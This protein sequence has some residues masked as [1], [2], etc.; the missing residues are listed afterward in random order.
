MG[1]V[2]K[3]SFVIPAYNE[4]H[5]V[6]DCLDAIL[7]Q[8]DG[9]PCPLEII[10]VNNASTDG[11][12]AVV[13]RYTDRGVTLV[14]EPEKGLVHA[15]RAGYDAATGDIIA[16]VDADT[17]ITPGWIDKVYRAFSG[18]PKLVAL[19]GPFV[20][21]DAPRSVRFWTLVFYGIGYVFYIINRFILR[22]GSMLQGGN[23]VVRR[24]AMDAIGGYDESISFYGE[25]S[26]VARRLSKVGKVRFTFRFPAFSSARRLAKEGSFMMGLR[27]SVN[28]FWM[29]F[30]KRPWTKDYIDIRFKEKSVANF[31]PEHK[32]REVV[33]ALLAFILFVVIVGGGSYVIYSLAE[34]GTVSTISLVQWELRARQAAS[35][36]E[37]RIEQHI[38]NLPTST[39]NM[40][41]GK[42]RTTSS[43]IATSTP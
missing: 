39:P 7:A 13:R 38:G 40:L 18:D 12:E 35:G 11:T 21:E 24:S 16:N 30:F 3:I 5:Y 32:L 31:N 33:L 17:R 19:S 6:A 43:A 26:D 15:R 14:N 1:N 22:V 27:Y 37:E 9:A 41:E 23:F 25:D 29:T 36:V 4:E 2:M 28:Y 20:Y 42:Y 10:V 8:K 34:T